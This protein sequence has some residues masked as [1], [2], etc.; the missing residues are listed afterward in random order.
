M[1][2]MAAFAATLSP[3]AAL[4]SVVAP[5]KMRHGKGPVLITIITIWPSPSGVSNHTL[6]LMRL[7]ILDARQLGD[8]KRLFSLWC[9]GSL[10]RPRTVPP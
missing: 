1:F 6:S 3:L 10:P 4:V 7:A 2:H 8:H 9:G 5:G